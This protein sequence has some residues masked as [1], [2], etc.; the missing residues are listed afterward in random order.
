MLDEQVERPTLVLD[1]EVERP[2]VGTA[3]SPIIATAEP[4][5]IATVDPSSQIAEDASSTA[6]LCE[7]PEKSGKSVNSTITQFFY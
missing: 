4:P 5:I 6:S 7:T 1:E 3:D 2:N